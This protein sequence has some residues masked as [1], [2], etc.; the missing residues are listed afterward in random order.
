MTT[1]SLINVYQTNS[2]GTVNG[3]WIQDHIGTLE[4]A[5]ERAVETNAVNSNRLDIAIV[6]GVSS[7]V[8]MLDDHRNLKRL[9]A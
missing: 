4:T 8:P 6:K 2:N 1:F 9:N 5:I 7:V 3:S